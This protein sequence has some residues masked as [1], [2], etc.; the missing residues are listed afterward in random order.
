MGDMLSGKKFRLN[1]TTLAVENMAEE[2]RAVQ[3]P[4]GETITVLS[5]PKPSDS[6]MVD[7]LWNNRTLLMFLEDIQRRGQEISDSSGAGA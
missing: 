1:N 6:R 3:V 2:R 7:V 4:A 5:G